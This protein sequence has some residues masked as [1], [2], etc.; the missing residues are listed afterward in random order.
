MWSIELRVLN[1]FCYFVDL[2]F[3]CSQSVFYRCN[4]HFIRFYFFF[5]L[6]TGEIVHARLKYFDEMITPGTWSHYSNF[7][8]VVIALATKSLIIYSTI[9][10]ALRCTYE[11]RNISV[12][13]WFSLVLGITRMTNHQKKSPKERAN[14]S[15]SSSLSESSKSVNY[16]GQ[17]MCTQYF[18]LLFDLKTWIVDASKV[19]CTCH[20]ITFQNEN[21]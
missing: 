18:I 5:I 7:L 17:P 13:S 1:I 6:K 15:L 19:F 4:L 10:Y 2:Q 11:K 21:P 8:I 9:R 3:C 12:S 20:S 16:I 14:T